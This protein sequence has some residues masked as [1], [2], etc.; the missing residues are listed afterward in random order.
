MQ[1]GIGENIKALRLGSKMTLK[2]LSEATGLSIGFLSQVERGLTALA[3]TSLEKIAKAL[4]VDLSYFFPIK[5]KNNSEILKSYER[6]VFQVENNQLI[7]YHLSNQLSK[8]NIIPKLV[9]I[10]PMSEDED[11]PVNQHDGEEFVYVLE[12]VF[13]L[14]L[15]NERHDLY[16]GDSA[17][18]DS[19]QVHNWAN[20]TSKT[21]KILVVHTPNGFKEKED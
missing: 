1:Q 4:E 21:V 6:E 9:E 13:T 20:F 15:N 14:I 16:P 18:F 12:G 7:H 5:S 17:H 8:M 11:V 10:L 19:N 3:I 2:D